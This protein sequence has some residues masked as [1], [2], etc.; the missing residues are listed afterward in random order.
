[1]LKWIKKN[2]HLFVI[3]GAG[4]IVF[5]FFSK[6]EEYVEDY[7]LKI[8]ALEAKVDSLHT[9]NSELVKESKV[10]ENQLSKYDKRIKN[11]NLKINV[12]K[13]ETQQKIDAVDSFGD[14]ELERFFT[15]RYLK[16]KGQQKDTIN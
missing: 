9:E 10:L 4:I 1:M 12:I 8:Q 15:E 11:L 7:S 16:V 3:L 6:K 13:N 14:D 5:N 2:Y